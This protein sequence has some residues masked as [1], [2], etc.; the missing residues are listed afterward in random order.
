MTSAPKTT[1]SRRTLDQLKERAKQA[2]MREE[3][4]CF[5]VTDDTCQMF[6]NVRH[7]RWFLAAVMLELTKTVKGWEHLQAEVEGLKS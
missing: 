5:D 2:I 1:K 6:G 4:V 7:M 3:Q